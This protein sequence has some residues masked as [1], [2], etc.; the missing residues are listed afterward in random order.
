M[1]IAASDGHHGTCSLLLEKGADIAARNGVRDALIVDI[2]RTCM[3]SRAH[4]YTSPPPGDLTNPGFYINFSMAP[5]S[6]P[7][8][9]LFCSIP[10]SGYFSLILWLSMCL[11]CLC[12]WLRCGV[13]W[14]GG[15]PLSL[16]LWIVAGMVVV[17]PDS[18]AEGEALW[19]AC[20]YGD[21]EEMEKAIA[22]LPTAIS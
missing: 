1:H 20:N 19:P 7:C 13:V 3:P 2:Y 21:A 8:C 6:V 17:W 4:T 11:L 14:W 12:L 16:S 15:A 22:G 10:W 9:P 18:R 5:A